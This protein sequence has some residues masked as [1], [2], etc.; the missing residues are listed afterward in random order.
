MKLETERLIL[1]DFEESD[2]QAVH[3]YASDREV[4]I[5]APW[6]PN[7]EKETKSYINRKIT[8]Q[9][10][11]PRRDYTFALILKL[12]KKLIGA[13]S[14]YVS[15][16][17]NREGW[18]GYVLNRTYWNHGYTTEVVKR[19]VDLGFN[20][21]GLHRIYATCQPDNLP[22][23]RVLEKVG[24]RRE[25]HLKEHKHIKGKWRDSLL[26]AILESEQ[27][28]SCMVAHDTVLKE[29]VEFGWAFDNK[30][31]C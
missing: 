15:D 30:L 5:Y 13:C 26:Y 11:Q 2:W 3:E 12:E 16:P 19:V 25:G 22:S 29:S 4:V 24:M 31:N 6:G 17:T 14:I 7:T 10:E 8:N 18:I 28:Q 1:R 21:L 20:E 23:A 27:C 9:H